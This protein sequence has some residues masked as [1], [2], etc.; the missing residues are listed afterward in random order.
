MYPLTE[1]RREELLSY[2]RLDEL[3]SADSDLLDRIYLAAVS[4]MDA[5][6]VRE[7]EDDLRRASYDLCVNY[8]VADAW[9]RRSREDATTFHENRSFRQLLNQLKHSEPVPEMG[10]G[11]R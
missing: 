10:T 6:G 4:Y 9:D 7:P 1:S 8:L 5:A 2:C 11:S 3:T